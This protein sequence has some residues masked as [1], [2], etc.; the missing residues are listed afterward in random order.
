MLPNSHLS[1]LREIKVQI[2]ITQNSY[3][4][5]KLIHN[6]R[7][8]SPIGSLYFRANFQAIVLS[9]SQQ[10]LWS[11]V[12]TTTG[13]P[14]KSLGIVDRKLRYP[15]RK[16]FLPQLDLRWFGHWPWTTRSLTPSLP[17]NSVVDLE[18]RGRRPRAGDSPAL[19]LNKSRSSPWTT[20]RIRWIIDSREM[21]GAA[22]I[23]I[24]ACAANTFASPTSR[25]LSPRVKRNFDQLQGSRAEIKRVG[26]RRERLR[27]PPCLLRHEDELFLC[28]SKTLENKQTLWMR[29]AVCLS[30]TL[31]DVLF[32]DCYVGIVNIN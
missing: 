23:F 12:E 6:T 13:N 32:R 28:H 7:S 26:L 4:M 1:R 24:A 11:H 27:L 18:R 8:S 19:N 29:L 10:L 3:V 15:R 22:A 9:Y 20:A 5:L 16:S 25:S 2:A 30:S 14:S 17:A 31:S 21:R